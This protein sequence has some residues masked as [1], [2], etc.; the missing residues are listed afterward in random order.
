M[1]MPVT[2]KGLK[3]YD[4][5]P[6]VEAV[7]KAWSTPGSFPGAHEHAKRVVQDSMPLL[8]RAIERLVAAEIRPSFAVPVGL[9]GNKEDHDP[10]IHE[11]RSLGTYFCHADQSRRLPYCLEEKQK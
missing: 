2:P 11:S 5:L 7:K 3:K 10:H 6:P 8:F 4:D 9:C 1:K